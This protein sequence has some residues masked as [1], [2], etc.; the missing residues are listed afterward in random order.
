LIR[1]KNGRTRAAYL[2]GMTMG[3]AYKAAL[4]MQDALGSEATHVAEERADACR[5]KGDVD[6]C[7]YW[8]RVASFL[9]HLSRSPSPTIH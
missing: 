3:D 2:G 4:R 1:V 8:Q 5:S 9:G 6:G 7:R